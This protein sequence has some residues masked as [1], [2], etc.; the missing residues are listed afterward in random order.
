MP[1]MEFELQENATLITAP[2]KASHQITKETF[3]PG[4]LF[5]AGIGG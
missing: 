2:G 1:R 4:E 5:M 3:G